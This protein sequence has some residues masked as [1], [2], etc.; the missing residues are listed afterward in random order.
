MVL[1]YCMFSIFSIICTSILLSVFPVDFWLLA[2]CGCMW[3]QLTSWHFLWKSAFSLSELPLC[4]FDQSYGGS[5]NVV[6]LVY[7]HR[8]LGEHLSIW[9]WRYKKS[10]LCFQH[11]LWDFFYFLLFTLFWG[12]IPL[13][14]LSSYYS[15]WI[16]CCFL[17]IAHLYLIAFVFALTLYCQSIVSMISFVT[18]CDWYLVFYK[19]LVLFGC[20]LGD[21]RN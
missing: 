20:D 14:E 10:I 6:S 21:I 9:W 7:D 5:Q 4:T 11:C 18:A 16:F 8:H 3:W 2:G 15:Y 1:H 19:M 17:Y 13:Y 12:N